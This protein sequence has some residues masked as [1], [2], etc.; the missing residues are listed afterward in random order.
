M[1][2]AQSSTHKSQSDSPNAALPSSPASPWE[3]V[4]DQIVDSIALPNFAKCDQLALASCGLSC[5]GEEMIAGQHG[6]IDPTG[7]FS[8]TPLGRWPLG[9]GGSAS[10]A[11][12]SLAELAQ[13]EVANIR[14][15]A[16]PTPG[17]GRYQYSNAG[18][19]GP[20]DCP[21]SARSSIWSS[22][23][24][25]EFG[26]HGAWGMSVVQRTE[27]R[28]PDTVPPLNLNITKKVIKYGQEALSILSGGKGKSGVPP[29][30]IMAESESKVS[31]GAGKNHAG[32]FG[33][34]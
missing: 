17:R 34:A 5:C 26:G 32:L 2:D 19:G 25:S 21:Y 24:S 12:P 13:A 27:S 15:T 1:G 29:D 18:G 20:A 9:P 3:Q 4:A 16:T 6:V 31:A 30:Y 23:S 14:A 10:A 22:G 7:N 8:A 33:G 28:R 11:T